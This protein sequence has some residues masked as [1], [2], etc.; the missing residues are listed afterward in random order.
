[1]VLIGSTAGNFNV[2]SLESTNH[3]LIIIVYQAKWSVLSWKN[4]IVK[5]APK[6]LSM[7][8]DL[9]GFIQ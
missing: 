8:L 9:V 4:G 2:I 7:L 3:I 1:M 6:V 5:I